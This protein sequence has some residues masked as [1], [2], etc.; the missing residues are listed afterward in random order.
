MAVVGRVAVV[1]SFEIANG[2]IAVLLGLD[3]LLEADS[4]F[5]AA[6]D[7]ARAF[8]D[9]T[10]HPIGGLFVAL[11]LVLLASTRAPYRVTRVA[12]VVLAAAYGFLAAGFATAAPGPRASWAPAIF[13]ALAVVGL[14]LTAISADIRERARS[15]R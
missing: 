9:G 2:L 15:A 4:N 1:A 13:S 12:I 5:S 8:G 3:W 6:Y 7:P 11:G 14:V 10:L